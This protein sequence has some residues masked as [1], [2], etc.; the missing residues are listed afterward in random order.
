M[1]KITE[2]VLENYIV[3]HYKAYMTLI[4]DHEETLNVKK[5]QNNNVFGRPS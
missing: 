3:C 2:D 4:A 5:A 1:D